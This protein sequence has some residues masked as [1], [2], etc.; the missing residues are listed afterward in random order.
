MHNY[1]A[2]NLLIPDLGAAQHCGFNLMSYLGAVD[3]AWCVFS[4]FVSESLQHNIEHN[5][6]RVC[7]IHIKRRQ[8]TCSCQC[9]VGGKTDRYCCYQ[10]LHVWLS[11]T[12]TCVI[13]IFSRL[14]CRKFLPIAPPPQQTLGSW[15]FMTWRYV[16]LWANG[17]KSATNVWLRCG[18]AIFF[19]FFFTPLLVRCVCL[20]A[21]PSLPVWFTSSLLFRVCTDYTYVRIIDI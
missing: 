15:L 20:V 9:S 19:F 17:G 3:D 8:L 5:T 14:L 4:F 12:V 6:W 7:C 11:C 16:W 18:L 2:I 13:S 1:N 21:S 10:E